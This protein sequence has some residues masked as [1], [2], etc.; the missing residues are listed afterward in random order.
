ISGGNIAILAG[1]TLIIFRVAGFLGQGAMVSAMAGL[2][3]YGYLV[4]GGA[5]VDRATMM[6]VVDLVGRTLDL[7]GPP[8]NALVLVA[9][10]LLAIDPLS[11][12]DPA[13]L[14][15][16]G[17]TA[18][19]ITMSAE[20]NR[21]KLPRVVAPLAGMF[22]ASVAAEAALLPVSATIFS[23]VTF[24]GLALNFFAIP[25]MAVAQI[26]GMMI[27]PLFLV[28]ERMASGVGW[29]AYAGAEG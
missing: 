8:I 18:A 27:V 23:R 16:F 2:I 13:F 28:S 19:I 20:V 9:G 10:I 3:G 22:V 7:R 1:L 24:A 11:I 14:L 15:T 17:A 4:G 21:R 29:F 12:V 26:A 6:A 5:S 25:L